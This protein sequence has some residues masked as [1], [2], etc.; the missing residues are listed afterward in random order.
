MSENRI[1]KNLNRKPGRGMKSIFLIL[2]LSFIFLAC[3]CP[4]AIRVYTAYGR[5]QQ[6][7]TGTGNQKASSSDISLMRS[8]S[9]FENSNAEMAKSSYDQNG[10]EYENGFGKVTASDI[11]ENANNLLKAEEKFLLDQEQ[12]ENDTGDYILESCLLSGAERLEKEDGTVDYVWRAQN[13]YADHA[14]VFR[15]SYAFSGMKE[16]EEGS[17]KIRI[18]NTILINRR[19][20]PADRLEMSIPEEKEEGLTE[21]NI[22]VYKEEQDEYGNDVL[23]I[24]NRVAIAAAAQGYVEAAYYTSEETY[25]YADYNPDRKEEA[26]RNGNE[27]NASNDFYSEL[28]INGERKKRGNE[29]PVYI[30]TST[31]ISG[32]SKS[33]PAYYE[34]WQESWGE[35][36]EDADN[37]YYLIWEIRTSIARATQSYDFSIK[38]IF[39]PLNAEGEICGEVMAY[40][41]Q[42]EKFVPVLNAEGQVNSESGIV[43]DIRENYIYGRYDYVLTRH[44]KA[45]YDKYDS[46][47][48]KNKVEAKIN[49]NDKVDLPDSKMAER[50]WT[51]ERKRFTPPGGKFYM[52]KWGLDQ[53]DIEVDDSEDIRAFS[54]SEFMDEEKPE[55]NAIEDLSFQ[56]YVEGFPG[57]YT[58][59]DGEDIGDVLNYWKKKISYELTDYNFYLKAMEGNEYSALSKADYQIDSI[60]METYALDAVYSEETKR[61]LETQRGSYGEDD[62]VKVFIQLDGETDN[63]EAAWTHI[64]NYYLASKEY[65]IDETYAHMIR[66]NSGPKLEFNNN[67]MQDVSTDAEGHVVTGFRLTMDSSHYYTKL[68]AR[69]HVTIRHSEAVDAAAEMTLKDGGQSKIV[70]M[71]MASSSVSRDGEKIIGFTRQGKSYVVG[72]KREGEIN[73]EVTHYVNDKVKEEYR[74]TWTAEASESYLSD[75]NKR[76][77]LEQQGG[78]FYDLLPNGSTYQKG[79]LQAYANENLLQEGQYSIEMIQNYGGSGRIML[80]VRLYVPAKKYRMSY[81]TLHT[82][83]SIKE[84]GENVLND[85]AYETG[86]A[87]IGDGVRKDDCQAYGNNELKLTLLS[88]AAEGACKFLYTRSSHKINALTAATLGL[89]K[90]VMS[91]ND[92]SY[93]YETYVALAST[94]SYRIRFASSDGKSKASGLIL[95]DFLENYMPKAPE[96]EEEVSENGSAGGESQNWHGMLQDIDLSQVRSLGVEPVVYFYGDNDLNIE[97]QSQ[98]QIRTPEELRE[99]LKLAESEQRTINLSELGWTTSSLYSEMHGGDLSGV[100]AIA[101]DLRKGKKGNFILEP[102]KAVVVTVYMK[103]PDRDSSIASNSKIDSCAYNNIYSYAVIESENGKLSDPEFI[104]QDYTTVHLRATGNLEIIKTSSRNPETAVEGVRFQLRGKSD[105]GTEY[106]LTMETNRFGSARFKNIEKGVYTIQ[107]VDGVPDYQQDHTLMRIRVNSDGSITLGEGGEAE[108]GDEQPW[109]NYEK[110]INFAEKTQASGKQREYVMRIVNDPRIHGNLEFMK[111]GGIDGSDSTRASYGAVFLLKGI[112]EYGNE[113]FLYAESGKDGKVL[114]ENL[115]LGK[116]EM[117][118]VKAEEGYIPSDT[119]YSV[120]CGEDGMVNMYEK[121]KDGNEARLE[122]DAV[123]GEIILNNEPLHSFYLLKQDAVNKELLEGAEF[124]ISGKSLYGHFLEIEAITGKNGVAEMSGL[125]PGTYLLEETKA[126]EK[127]K[128]DEKKYLVKI[129]KDGTVGIEGLQ[130]ISEKGFEGYFSFPNE[131]LTEGVITIIKHW[132]DGENPERRTVPVIHMDTDEPIRSLPTARIKRLS[133]KL[134]VGGTERNT[135]FLRQGKTFSRNSVLSRDEVLRKEG[136]VQIDDGTTDYEIYVWKENDDVIWWSNAAIVYLPMDSSGLFQ[137]SRVESI[138]LEGFDSSQVVYMENMFSSCN[139]VKRLDLGHFNTENVTNMSYMFSNCK[140]MEYLDISGFDTGKVRNMTCMFL[141]CEKM[142]SLDVA[143]FNTRNVT[144]MDNMFRDCSN[145]KSLELDMWETPKLTSMARMFQGCYLLESLKIK[146]FDTSKVESFDFLFAADR[147]LKNLDLAEWKTDSAESMSSMF[148][149]CN[150]LEILDLG[151]FYTGKVRT[152]DYMFYGGGSDMALKTIIVGDGWVMEDVYKSLSMFSGCVNLTGGSGT[153]FDRTN[154]D[155]AYARIDGGEESPGYFTAKIPSS[156]NDAYA[157]ELDEDGTEQVNINETVLTDSIEASGG[158]MNENMNISSSSLLQGNALNTAESNR[159]SLVSSSEIYNGPSE[160]SEDVIGKWVKG[161]IENGLNDNVWIYRFPVFDADSDYYVW[162]GA[163]EAYKT[164]YSLDGIQYSDGESILFHNEEG[165]RDGTV[166]VKN[167]LSETDDTGSLT[168]RKIVKKKS[169]DGMDVALSEDDKKEAFNFTITLEKA[170]TGYYG[171]MLF[172]GGKANITLSHGQSQTATGLPTGIAYLVTEDDSKGMEE[173]HSGESGVITEGSNLE[174]IF[175]NSIMETEESRSGSLVISK[176]LAARD[177]SVNITGQDRK[178]K[179]RFTITLTGSFDDKGEIKDASTLSRIIDGVLFTEGVA[180]VVLSDGDMLEIGGIPSG[181]GYTVSEEEYAGFTVESSGTEQGYIPDGEAAIVNFIN[182][183][184]ENEKFGSITL[185]KELIGKDSGEAFRFY[186]EMSG[187]NPNEEYSYGNGK[188]FLS[189]ENGWARIDVTLSNR[190]T[191]TFG[192]LPA[193][194]LCKATE[195]ESEYCASY[196]ITGGGLSIFKEGKNDI[197]QKQLSTEEEEVV[198]NVEK[199]ITFRNTPA[200]FTIRFYKIDTESAGVAGALLQVFDVEAQSEEPVKEWI[201]SGEE[202][203]ITLPAGKYLLH[204]KQAPEGYLPAEDIYFSLD[205]E[206]NIFLLHDL[207]DEKTQEDDLQKMSEGGEILSVS[208]ITMT[209]PFC[210]VNFAKEDGEGNSL[211]GAELQLLEDGG[212]IHEWQS[213]NTEECIRQKL[214]V[215]KIYTF[216]EKKAPEGYLLSK[217]I[218]FL[219]NRDGSLTLTDHKGKPLALEDLENAHAKIRPGENNGIPILVMENLK[220]ESL[221]RTGSVGIRIFR[222]IG[223]SMVAAALLGMGFLSIAYK[224]RRKR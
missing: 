131:R 100:K 28:W 116:Y 173:S 18:P 134:N 72:R 92:S 199:I 50:Q 76:I 115:E 37:Y 52:Y 41:M 33:L 120:I 23:T 207:D 42:G 150:S 77:R 53:N 16:L 188:T 211:P 84:Y 1:N 217:D 83:D 20:D 214:A 212:I 172:K 181:L 119:K 61:F 85:L 73:K 220:S 142:S 164:A 96:S 25:E 149:G 200:L 152:M 103:S 109:K 126:P 113:V 80:L 189:D 221:P 175:T 15:I 62:L 182:R 185:R 177:E 170:I 70:L 90:K 180:H 49:P 167:S 56:T 74:I 145:L 121:G 7:L 75:G 29:I 81:T 154:T 47:S 95:F 46:Y 184:E 111:R 78:V 91:E 165:K 27:R 94:Y 162:E 128:A 13:S 216:R 65:R 222:R 160:G 12:E 38:D 107:E 136:V 157:A 9:D 187:L 208:E 11:P 122:Q 194:S 88:D 102:E 93:S 156:Q 129:E 138:D 19:G 144:S 130:M 183:K 135:L 110:V 205:E 58:V 44:L 112:S 151:N 193:R 137:Y 71:N 26:A 97:E 48:L 24:Y 153:V 31:E 8:E 89:Y 57:I 5:D 17:V 210:V 186:V 163:M 209:D 147:T 6:V 190:E 127:Y 169:A 51:Y 114:F 86:N 69:P 54:L 179:F 178:R 43:R 108:A 4:L 133:W 63:G 35:K 106:D 14:F 141:R 118:E 68:G 202:E 146:N 218:Y 64:G 117:M 2:L 139:N 176:E 82:W 60:D 195:M 213:G 123:Y 45:E 198:E 99:K 168:V 79:S 30:D 132:D 191:V 219:I 40:M 223:M 197:K 87:D 3:L 196:E 161:N 21:E 140:K 155:G 158:T 159:L 174:A 201:T 39:E 10:W 215:G 148:H 166:H 67:Y 66:E 192:G 203:K 105:Y 206:G 22:F 143:G 101:I 224:E 36:T 59:P 34:T 98:T 204:E 124:R 104:H 125:E 55:V 171:D 32:V